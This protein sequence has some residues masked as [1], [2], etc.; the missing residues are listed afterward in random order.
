M[1][2]QVPEKE[3]F[4]MDQQEILLSDFDSSGYILD[5]GGGG[6]GTIGILKGEKVI[7]IDTRRE[8]LEEA[9]KRHTKWLLY[10]LKCR[11]LFILCR[12]SSMKRNDPK[13]L[14]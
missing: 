8:E 1:H 12:K 2:E 4:V 11:R 6:E 14:P 10:K 5:I 13:F 3:M 7:A 9:F